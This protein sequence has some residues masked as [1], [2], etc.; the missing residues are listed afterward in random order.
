MSNSPIEKFVI[1]DDDD[2][3]RTSTIDDIITY[4]FQKRR[5]SILSMSQP[6]SRTSALTL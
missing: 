2:S 6:S 5:N 1:T 3:P 4:P